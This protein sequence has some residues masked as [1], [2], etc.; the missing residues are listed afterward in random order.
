MT[1]DPKVTESLGEAYL[2]TYRGPHGGAPDVDATDTGP[3]VATAAEQAVP[4]ELIAAQERLAR[5]R[6]VGETLVAVYPGDDPGGF[7][8]A[9]QLV[10]DQAAMLLDSVT[11]L[12]HRLGVSYV[13]L[14]NPVF[15]VRRS[16]TGE[17]LDVRPASIDEP[18]GPES[19]GIDESWIHVQLSPSVNRKALAEAERMLPMAVADARQVAL[20]STALSAALHDLARDIDTD[21]GTRF[22]GPDR[23]DVADL[24]RWLSD[25]HFILLGCQ[26]CTVRDG[27]AT[28]VESSRLGVARLRTEVLPE[29]TN[30]GDVLVLAQATM[31]SFLRYGAYPYIVVIREHSTS[32]DVEHRF[33]GLF[34]AAAMSANVL[35]IPLISRRVRDV[36]AMSKSDPSHPGQLMLDII[37]TIPR[38]ELF[39]LTAEQ[40][41]AMATAVV[42]LGSRRRALLF[43]RAAQLGHFVSALVYLPRDRYTTVV[44]LAMQDIL[45]REFG[46]LSIDYTARV[47]ESPWAVVHFTVRLPDSSTRESI[48]DSERNRTRVQG[49]LTEALRTWGDR[50][51]GSARAGK[52]DQA[53][54]EHYA[55]ALPETF[56]QAVTSTEAIT[57]I[58]FI[59]ALH[60]DSVK[61][62]FEEGDEGNEAF[63][64][65]YLGG[66]TASLSHLLPMLQCMGVLVL[67]ERPF[68]V[69][70]PDGLKVWIYQF[71][72]RPDASMPTA[73]TQE[74][75]DATAQRFADAVTA[76]WQGRAEI[77]RFNELVLRAG[78]T[79]QQVAV[80]R[81]YAKYLRQAAFPYSQ[82]HIESVLN[83]NPGTAR[84]L[85]TLFEAM[86][87]PDSADKG[88]DALA[89]ADAVAADIDAL[90]SLD[91]DRVLRAF[92]TMIQA[93]LRTNYFVTS[94]DS[95]HAQN[96]LSLKLD[97]QLIDELP[98]PRPKFEIFVYSPRVEGVHLRFG[99]VAR[100]GLRWSDRRED[101]RTEILGLVKAQAVKNAVIVPVGAKG[102]FVVKRPSAPLGDAAA[103]RDAFR[104]EGIACYRLFIAGLLDVTDNVDRA[105]GQ[106]ITPPRVVRRDGD[107]AYLVVAADKGTATFSDIANDVAQSY[108]FWLGDAFA[109]G[110]SVGY[111]H[112]AMGIT[113][114]GAW[115]SVKRHFRE[116]GVD[117]QSQ[118]FTVVGVGDMSGDV[119][120]NGML[121]SHHIRLIAA[122]DHRHIFIDPDP[123]AERSWQERRRLFELPRSS[124]EDYDPSLIS[125][126]GGVFS[127]QQKSIPVSRQM[128]AAL[129]L[130]GEADEVTPPALMKAI[131]QAPV[132]LW[133]NG[134]I[135]TYIKAESESD[136][137]VGDRANDTIRVNGNQVR[138]KVIG[139]GGNLGVTSLGR[140]E[141]D[142]C[143]GRINTDAMDNSAGVDCSD[144]E[145]NIK[146]LVDSLVTAGKVSAGERTELLAS[147]T[148]E[149]S[150]LVLTDNVDQNDLMGTSRA[151]AAALL[152]V[153]ARQIVELEERRGL[154]RGLEALPSKK[155]I[156]R[157]QEVGI[158]LSSPE[159]AT[160]MAHVKLSL[161][162]DVLASELPDQ[163]VFAAR[164]PQ[165]F[166][167]Q[168]RDHF[169]TEIRG[170]QLRREITTT[171]LVNN[172]VDTGG[173]TF[174]YR[175]TEDTGVGYVDAVRTFVATDAIFGITKVWQR[176][177]DASRAGLPVNVSDR[178]TLDLRRLLDRA[179]RWLLNYRPQPLAVG[180][181]INRFAATLADLTP[182]MSEWLRGD[183]KAIVAK[184]A[185]EFEAHGAPADLAYTVASGLYQYSLLDVIDIA[186]IVDRD[187]AEVADT[188][189]ALMDHLSTDGLL[190]AVSG[191]PRDD[192]WHALARLAIRDDIYGSVRALCFDV[193]AVGEPEETG[194]EKIAEWEHTNGSRVERARR[195]LAEIYA[196]DERDLA[197]L[198][199]AARQ[200][201]SMTRTS[202]TGSSG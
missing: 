190:T 38:S 164:L 64:T 75:W 83:G 103:D 104:H 156:R 79:W 177:L 171:M 186:D 99:H 92:A 202:G 146:I 98:L 129:G 153:H 52:I 74:E 62:Q 154:N 72:I 125:A 179:S 161:K 84:S 34:T 80:L 78:L 40:L 133:F 16:A 137:E 168:L 44:R 195:T 193:L 114:K 48:D 142:L 166:P 191:L 25:G 176:I 200:I 187:P 11:V 39:S 111:D 60:E 88:L 81:A 61:L 118:D 10:T 173:I 29:L 71:K 175:V 73:A 181:E 107:D 18:A 139:E 121:L 23:S 82:S 31:P 43:L 172:V 170:H 41:L 89:A 199:V 49:L 65:W 136:A 124:W 42:D 50:L 6:S 117:T 157:R 91:T 122:F 58:G 192:R 77:D 105:T 46:G 86:F 7:G 19:D 55:E 158:G 152:N 151:N 148:D 140:V 120:G 2:A 135:G 28:V 95:A 63:L 70:R 59:E 3:L 51:I 8:P 32:G 141:F 101:F 76:I 167:S 30:P 17:L 131:M 102:G 160:L 96:V 21:E 20:D 14:M 162:D 165:Y 45:V 13:A 9:L 56:K 22:V 67:E 93:T 97:P 94:P 145:V 134:G 194:E 12:L 35:D 108:G 47:S 198:S 27:V 106:V 87:D 149:V 68:T 54:A 163:E 182:R 36:L 1:V 183:D 185:G 24:L 123:D 126:G 119:F 144:H 127:R 188:Y 150:R 201:R 115:E 174:A 180:A 169:T 113:A 128:R 138:A 90:V 26:D 100:G 196:D 147:M 5:D 4:H 57:D 197:T 66:S 53:I 109:S 33:V 116:M 15:R 155:E 159:L 69:V 189:F 37:Q 184:E 132:D 143:G 112:K 110:G 178:M 85:V 130:Q